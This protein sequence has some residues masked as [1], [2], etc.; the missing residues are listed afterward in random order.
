M[1]II[2]L[3]EKNIERLRKGINND[4]EF[5]L[6]SKYMT[7]DIHFAVDASDC[8]VKVRD[9]VVTEIKLN[10]FLESWTYSVEGPADSWQKFLLPVP[11]RN[12]NEIYACIEHRT[13]KLVGDLEA[14][15]AF[16]WA[17]TR[18]MDLFRELQ[19]SK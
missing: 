13:L 6:A 1:A 10:P 16:M 2:F 17:L 5:Q 3:D 12:Y 18:M 4:P 14:A 7:Q 9:G 11:P 19:N 8:L 15:S